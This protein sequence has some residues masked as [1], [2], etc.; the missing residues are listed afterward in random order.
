[1]FLRGGEEVNITGKEF[2]II[3]ILLTNRGTTI[4]R[5]QIIEDIWGEDGLFSSD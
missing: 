2:Q 3:E 5:T 1:M 4:S